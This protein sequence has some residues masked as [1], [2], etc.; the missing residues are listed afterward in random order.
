MKPSPCPGAGGL[1]PTDVFFMVGNPVPRKRRDPRLD[2]DP[3]AR[4][5]DWHPEPSMNPNP[6]SMD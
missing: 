4:A 5:A 3:R 6:C 1:G 2:G